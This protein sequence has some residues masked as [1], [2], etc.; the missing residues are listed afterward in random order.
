MELKVALAPDRTEEILR[1]YLTIEYSEADVSSISPETK[2]S[3]ALT[4]EYFSDYSANLRD[5]LIALVIFLVLA[6]VI[7]GFRI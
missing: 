1:P 5:A 4:V 7:S 3:V 6:L 2:G